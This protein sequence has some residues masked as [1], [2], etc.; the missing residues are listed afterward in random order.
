MNLTEL[1]V[2]RI[3]HGL[4]T[5]KFANKIGMPKTT[6]YRRLKNADSFTLEEIRNI[7]KALNLSST[8]IMEIFFTQ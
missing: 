4:T 6:L 2:E 7:S 5:D 8:R 3:R 1:K